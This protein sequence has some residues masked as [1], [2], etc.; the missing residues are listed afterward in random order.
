[1]K[2]LNLTKSFLEK[3]DIESLLN[4]CK[5]FLSNISKLWLNSLIENKRK[6]Q[7]LIFPEGIY[8]KNDKL[9]TAKINLI[10]S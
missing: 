5:Y 1:L 4:Y 8:I 9:R 7:D 3:I 6:L 10:L 2:E